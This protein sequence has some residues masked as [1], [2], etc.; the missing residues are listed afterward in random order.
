MDNSEVRYPNFA[1][2]W[3]GWR[4]ET[5]CQWTYGEL[6]PETAYASFDAYCER[7]DLATPSFAEFELMAHLHV[8]LLK[9]AVRPV[10]RDLRIVGSDSYPIV[11]DDTQALLELIDGKTTRTIE[12]A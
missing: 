7:H 4:T 2:M 12:Y 5:F 6:T 11:S 1:E 8:N 3:H 10:L 9:I